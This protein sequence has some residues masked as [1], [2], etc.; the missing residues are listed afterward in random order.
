MLPFYYAAITG[1]FSA[2]KL[3]LLRFCVFADCI[4]IIV[5]FSIAKSA[6]I[7][8]LPIARIGV[9]G[10][11]LLLELGALILSVPQELFVNRKETALSF[12][13]LALFV[14]AGG[15]FL[16]FRAQDPASREG[17]GDGEGNGLMQAKLFNFDMTPFLK[18]QNEIKMNDELVF[19]VKREDVGNAEER[20]EDRHI[21]MRRFILSKY[22]GRENENGF[23]SFTRSEDVDEKTQ[24]AFVPAGELALKQQGY[25]KRENV[26]QEY[27]I[28]NIDGS[29]FLAM[30]EP[31]RITP[32]RNYD[33]SSF[34]G[35]YGVD[36]MASN[37]EGIDLY[38]S[39]ERCKN[40]ARL[41]LS[42]DEFNWYTDY[43]NAKGGI[44]SSEQKIKDLAESLTQNADNY[45]EK[46]LNLVLY[47]S[48]GDFRYSLKPGIAPDGDQ[49]SYFLFDAK[50]GYCSYFAFALASML[51]SIKI[52]SR[53]VVGFYLDPETEKLNFYPVLSNMAHAWVEVWFPEYGW[54]EFD[55]TATEMAAGEDW[56]FSMGVS[57][58]LFEKLMKE[59]LDNRNK[60]QPKPAVREEDESSFSQMAKKTIDAA[61]RLSVP[62]ALFLVMVILAVHFFKYRLLAALSKQPRRKTIF[63]W[64]DI[65]IRLRIKRHACPHDKTE[66]EWIAS[67]N[68]ACGALLQSL[69]DNASQARYAE[70]YTMDDCHAFMAGYKTFAK[71]WSLLKALKPNMSAIALVFVAAFFWAGDAAVSQTPQA[72]A[73]TLYSEAQKSIDGENWERAIGLLNEGKRVYA[74]DYRFPLEL[75]NIYSGR[76]F[77]NLA[78]EEFLLVDKLLPDNELILEKLAVATASLNEYQDSAAYYKRIVELNPENV[79]T[80][81]ELA[82]M[83]FKIHKLEE[84]EE[85]L[86]S[87]I[88]EFGPSPRLA[89]TLAIIYSDMLNYEQSKYWYA[90]SISTAREYMLQSFASVAYYNY[91]ILESRF[92]RYRNSFELAE[93]SLLMAERD[94]GHMAK[95][96]LLLRRLEFSR[97]FSEYEKAYQLD[98]RSPLPKLSLAQSYLMSGRLE[99]A[100]LYAEDC[101]RIT[102]HSWMINFGIDPA[103]FKK[104]LSDVLH[105]TYLGLYNQEKLTAH[106]TLKDALKSIG[107]RIQYMF[108]YNVYKK[109]YEKHTLESAGKYSVDTMGSQYLDA[110]LN[111]YSAFSSYPSRAAT[112]LEKSETYELEKIPEAKN[113]YLYERGKLFG[114]DD[115]LSSALLSFDT[116]WERDMIAETYAEL[117]KI[118]RSRGERTTTWTIAEL[119]FMLNPGALRQA[120]IKLPVQFDINTETDAAR[121]KIKNILLRTGFESPSAKN[122]FQCRLDLK[123]TV[124]KGGEA[125]CSLIDRTDGSELAR[126]NIMLESL[127]GEA[128]A[129]FANELTN[130]VF[131]VR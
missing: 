20:A 68:L 82:W 16:I 101:E 13:L 56:T 97:V 84:G 37:A 31:E 125:R 109:L 1:F 47:L 118:A 76:E 14:L 77:Y 130:A 57:P 21:F 5:T 25:K 7:Y 104:E 81:V 51:R 78:K 64:K 99:E 27:Y 108:K 93:N 131:K 41:G 43:A 87:T 74:D 73:E 33:V 35:I 46:T 62:F 126:I 38:Q 69:Y 111:Y 106:G 10:V 75:G 72:D 65:L 71:Q 8:S 128:L 66:G 6:D 9:F 121:A 129:A 124:D 105:K 67:L 91:S 122:G 54:I 94:S 45:F 58:D 100:R 55:P 19:I 26:T 63:L 36:S 112:Y 80:R 50:K 52:P 15:I 92:Y 23:S 12:A 17:G 53:V 30:N 48:D 34:K 29:A 24:R 116:L 59:I 117:Y 96:E 2:R 44:T 113:A 70:E 3:K 88:E 110:L 107:K 11:L 123:I 98:K 28:V 120:H 89:M 61:R 42:P 18:L 90:D 79:D 60:L 22:A 4:L 86:L 85:L 40:D 127:S 39:A 32:Y 83:Y 102:N 114:D 115:L 95:G 49:L 119:L 103:Q